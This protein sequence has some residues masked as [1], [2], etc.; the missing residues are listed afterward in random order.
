VDKVSLAPNGTLT[1]IGRADNSGEARQRQLL[2]R[3]DALQRDLAIL[4]GR[5]PGASAPVPG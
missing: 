4:V 1:F 3:M 2:E 5:D